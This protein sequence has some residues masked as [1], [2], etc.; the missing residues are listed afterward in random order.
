M[1][2]KM[3]EI[4]DEAIALFR[5]MRKGKI[6]PEEMKSKTK[7]L[8]AASSEIAKQIKRERNEI[9]AKRKRLPR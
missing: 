8:K 1:I 9:S 4:Q 5:A 3:N 7:L 6:K 2:E